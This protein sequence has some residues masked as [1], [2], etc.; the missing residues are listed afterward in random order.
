[1]SNS[2]SSRCMFMESSTYISRSCATRGDGSARQ[3]RVAK[4][5]LIIAGSRRSAE[6]ASHSRRALDRPLRYDGELWVAIASDEARVLGAFQRA[7]GH[8]GRLVRRGSGGPD[9]LVGPGTVH[10]ALA[11]AH[12][13]SLASCDEKRI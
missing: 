6:I 5:G 10:V 4:L 11:L 9:V 2:P 12:P 7:E 3:Q 13:A 8:V 1:M